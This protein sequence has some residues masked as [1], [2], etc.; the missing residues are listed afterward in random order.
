[1]K[2]LPIILISTFFISLPATGMTAKVKEPTKT[3]HTVLKGNSAGEFSK[4]GLAVEMSYKSE[5][6][7]TG[8]LSNVNVILS[9]QLKTGILKVN[10]RALDKTLVGLE[11]ENLEFELSASK[12]S[13]PLDLQ[14]SSLTSGIHYLNLTVSIEG[15]GSRVFAVPI[16]IGTISNKIEKQTLETSD[17]GINISVSSAKEEIK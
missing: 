9:T 5:H 3:V 11:N 16:N 2:T 4:R 17:T 7:E 1:M 10:L 13:F 14:L 8:D 15:E 12:R 6:V